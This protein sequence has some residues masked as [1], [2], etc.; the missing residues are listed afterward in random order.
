MKRHEDGE[1]NRRF[2]CGIRVARHP[3]KRPQARAALKRRHAAVRKLIFAISSLVL[4]LVP[5]AILYSKRPT[6]IAS[7][8][9]VKTFAVEARMWGWT[10]ATIEVERGY[11][12]AVLD[13]LG[14]DVEHDA[15]AF[16]DFDGGW[17][18]TPH[19]RFHSDSLHGPGGTHGCW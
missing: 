5:A 19:A 14:G 1:N 8:G 18:P 2:A 3:T 6:A 9:A 16:F 13:I 17:R 10:P 12:E 15:I 7:T 11:V 4:V